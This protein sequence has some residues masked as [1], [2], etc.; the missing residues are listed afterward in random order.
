VATTPT[1]RHRNTS[2]TIRH[3]TEVTLR[4]AV[5]ASVLLALPIGRTAIAAEQGGQRSAPAAS[6]PAILGYGANAPIARLG[7]E[8]VTLDDV[9]PEIGFQVYRRQLDI[10]ALLRR[11]TEE[12]VERRLLER[13]A[14]RRGVSVDELLANET[15]ADAPA[16]SDADIEAYF[17][18][19][20]EAS[21]QPNARER[22]RYYL[23]EKRKIERRLAFVAGLREKARFE[24]L[25]EPP[26]QP[27]VEV[28]TEGAPA[29]GPADAPVTIVHFASFTSPRSARTAADLTKLV[30]EL[31]G[32]VRW[33]HRNL[34]RAHD[35]LGLA[36]AQLAVEAEAHGKFWDLHDRLFAAGGR[37]TRDDL[38]RAASQLGLAAIEPGSIE[39]LDT[40]KKDLDLAAKL[41]VDN[42]P[43]FFING[44][45]LDGT[46]PYDR[47]REVVL[48]ELGQGDDA[49]REEDLY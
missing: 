18:E 45:Y 31:P 21:S 1:T 16:A 34:P 37:L 8:T 7:G 30:A 41:G 14:A 10:Y 17:A 4:V 27:R 36:A 35:E 28:P 26:A 33:V 12:L 3:R 44:R 38:E 39:N 49:V 47:L 20:A 22:V 9:A 23:T 40:V 24:F 48:E 6:V 32:R 25:L 43:V 46:F 42:E 11:A 15:G 5:A 29:R 13:E 2:G 19:H